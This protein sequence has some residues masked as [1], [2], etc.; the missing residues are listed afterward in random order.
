MVHCDAP[1]N[2]GALPSVLPDP[3]DWSDYAE[4]YDMLLAHNPAYR[5]LLL[6]FDAFLTNADLPK[7]PRALDAGAGTGNFSDALLKTV[8]SAHL[9]LL[10]PDPAMQAHALGKLTNPYVE[11]A[12]VG[13]QDYTGPADFDLIVCTHALYTMPDPQARL[14]QMRDLIRPGGWLFLIDFGRVLRIWDWRLYLM[15][16]LIAER[17]L[18]A[19]L[20]VMRRGRAVARA[21][22]DIAQAQRAGQYWT[23]STQDLGDAAGDAGWQIQTLHPVYRGYS[24][25]LIARAEGV[26][27]V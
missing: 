1:A 17:G 21:N 8:P 27:H 23:H 10:E 5:D 6:A 24:D 18:G 16:H 11:L 26:S 19:A 3:V 25:L 2:A 14:A 20:A 7:A 15:R 12:P 22:G 4:V 9:T 13:L